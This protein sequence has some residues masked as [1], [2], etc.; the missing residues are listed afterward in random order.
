MS[1]HNYK[2]NI[3]ELLSLQRE[4]ELLQWSI[5]DIAT[6]HKRTPQAIIH[7]LIEEELFFIN[8]DDDYSSDDDENSTNNDELYEEV[9]EDEEEDEDEYTP[10]TI[11]V[12]NESED[13]SE[14][15]VTEKKELPLEDKDIEYLYI[16]EYLIN[17]FYNYFF[18]HKI[19]YR[20]KLM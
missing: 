19:S 11:W 6:K 10:R 1:R 3:N 8:D 9:E 5:P 18:P 15:T 16:H 2:W 4:Y 14:E 12:T 7:K 20:Y 13:E 17:L